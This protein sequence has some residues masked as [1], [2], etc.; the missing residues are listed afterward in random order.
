MY[1][2][3]CRRAARVLLRE[4]GA[5]SASEAAER[6]EERFANID[7]G[8]FAFWKKVENVLHTLLPRCVA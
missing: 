4:H 2:S 3:I 5:G 8:G 7:V 1:D 6:A